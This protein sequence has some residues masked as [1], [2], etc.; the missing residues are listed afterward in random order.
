MRKMLGWEEQGE[1][2]L[3]C[4]EEKDVSVAELGGEG[5]K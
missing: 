5:R 1:L 3:V 4:W 2:S